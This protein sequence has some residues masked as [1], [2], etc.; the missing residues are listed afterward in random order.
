MYALGIEV[1]PTR[2]D[3]INLS[4]RSVPLVRESRSFRCM[5]L[6]S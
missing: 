2:R 1:H 3:P 6:K 4:Q 5:Y